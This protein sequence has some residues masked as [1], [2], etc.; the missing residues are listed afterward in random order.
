MSWLDEYKKK[1]VTADEAVKVIKSG[2]W[3]EYA[4]GVAGA[5]ELDAALARRIDELWDV[6]IRCDIGAWPHYT[7]EADPTGEHFY[8]NSWHCG[9]LDRKYYNQGVLSYIP[10]K[11]HECPMMTRKDADPTNVFMATVSPMD[12]HGYFSFGAGC[13][14]AWA[15]I[16]KAQYVLLEVNTNMPRVLGGNQESIHISQVDYVVESS[17]MPLP[18]IPD[19]APSETEQKIA[20]HIIARLYNGNC[21]QLGIGGI[22]NAMGAMIAAS[23]LKDLGVHTEMYVDA[24]VKMTKAGKVTGACKSVDKYKQVFSFAMGTKELYDFIDDNPGIISY[25]VD[26]TNSPIVVAGIDDFVSI[27][28]CIEADLFG[29]VCSESVGPRH[30]SGT[31]GQLDF[32]EGAYKSKNGQSFICMTSTFEGKNGTV[33]RIKPIL[34]PGAIVTSPRTATHMIATEY[35]IADMKGKS[36]WE[37]AEA[38]INIAHPK[39]RDELIKEADQMKIWRKS[40]KIAAES[41]S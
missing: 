36:T 37:R 5:N 18:T 27:N 29:Q 34:T 10:M 30:I 32:V 33:S 21:I 15:A 1:L 3:V 17:N 39:F 14:S 7:N 16:E 38:L 13:P 26:Y 24:Y 9:G 31:G 35:G 6:K 25:S 20:E 2:D 40:N 28:A 8:W 41:S 12:K 23:D 22:P 11:F 4:F 19:V